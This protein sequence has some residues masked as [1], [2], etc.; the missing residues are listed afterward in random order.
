[1]QAALPFSYKACQ[2]LCCPFLMLLLICHNIDDHVDIGE[3]VIGAHALRVEGTF[4]TGRDFFVFI[5]KFGFQ[6]TDI[7]YPN[8]TQGVI[9]GNITITPNSPYELNEVSENETEHD[10]NLGKKRIFSTNY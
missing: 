10:D 3:S 8:N 7:R 6:K 4:D 1:M 9:Y 5:A 2:T